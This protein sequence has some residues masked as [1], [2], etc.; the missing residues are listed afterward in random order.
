MIRRLELALYESGPPPSEGTVVCQ[1]GWLMFTEPAAPTYYRNGV[2]RSVLRENE[3]EERIAE[4][5]SHFRRVGTS[6]RWVI[7]P[8]S[9]PRNLPRRLRACGFEHL[10]TLVGMVA[11]P[12]DF[13]APSRSEIHIEPVRSA[14][15]PDWLEVARDAWGMPPPALERFSRTMKLDLD[16]T[17]VTHMI[18][19]ADGKPVGVASFALVDDYAHFSGGAVVP[20]HRGNG[21]Y[22]ELVRARMEWLRRLDIRVVTSHNLSTTSAPIC[23]RL[24]FEAV[25]EFEVY[26]SS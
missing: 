25:C 6:F 13:A 12:A 15:L 22:T 26:T 4:T 7:T 2:V 3:V 17:R 8:S 24:G 10:E 14:T 9:R 18:A 1:D 16:G 11:D 5:I 20:E 21:V 19:R 23:E